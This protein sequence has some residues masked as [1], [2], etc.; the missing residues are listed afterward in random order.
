LAGDF[1]LWCRFADFTRLESLD[2][3]VSVFRSHTDQLSTNMS[4]YYME[5]DASVANRL[6]TPTWLRWIFNKI[7]RLPR[8]VARPM[9]LFAYPKTQIRYWRRDQKNEFQERLASSPWNY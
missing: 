6:V 7:D 2:Q 4:A 1:A 9:S 3:E 8:Q 5:C